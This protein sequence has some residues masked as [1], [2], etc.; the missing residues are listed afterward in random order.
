[1]VEAPTYYPPFCE[2][3]IYQPQSETPG[4]PGSSETGNN[5]GSKVI[6]RGCG[7]ATADI[8]TNEPI[9]SVEA[10]GLKCEIVD[11]KR[12]Y[13]SGPES[14]TG[15]VTVCVQSEQE[16]LPTILGTCPPGY[17][18][19]PNDPTRCGYI[20]GA[21][22][23]TEITCIGENCLV[24]TTNEGGRCGPGAYFDT[25]AERCVSYGQPGE[26]CLPG[27]E[28]DTQALCCRSISGEYPGCYST[29][30]CLPGSSSSESNCIEF[31]LSMGA[32]S[33]RTGNACTGLSL[34]ACSNNTRCYWD[35]SAN[36]CVPRP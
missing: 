19:D 5:I 20:P 27:Y 17:T 24:S 13:C 29:E 6:G 11:G 28:F 15:V 36:S 26:N 22:A 31:S 35:T 30:Q 21:Q 14:A 8:I 33:T 18:P 25:L 12:I 10:S 34:S 7:F 4:L 9:Q 23:A 3:S 16:H 1:M 32:C 2:T